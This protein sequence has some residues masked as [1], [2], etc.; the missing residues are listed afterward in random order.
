MMV[1]L[2][3]PC[4]AGETMAVQTMIRLCAVLLLAACA[5]PAPVPVAA[6][7]SQQALKVDLSN[8]TACSAPLQGAAPWE[9]D[10]PACALH[11]LVTP[12]AA[13]HPVRLAF[14]AMIAAL[15]AGNLVAPMADITLTDGAGRSH[16]F[17][18]PITP[19]P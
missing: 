3:G 17:T 10:L 8:G 18:S 9:G 11:F 1:G 13:G 4:K 16:K 2:F 14:D 7:L 6:R 5:L 15:R 12:T 19:T